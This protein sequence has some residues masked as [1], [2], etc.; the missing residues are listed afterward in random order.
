MRELRA[1]TYDSKVYTDVNAL[2][3]NGLIDQET[4]SKNLTYLWGKDSDMFPLLSMTQAQDAFKSITPKELNDTQYTWPV[5]GRMKWTTKIVGLAASGLS[6]P[7]KT[8]GLF[9][10]FVEDA[11]IH[12][13]YS[14]FTPD[15]LHQVRFMSEPKFV[16]TKKYRVTVQ[17]ITSDPAEYVSL[18]NFYAGKAWAMGS[19]S[20][21]GSLSDGTTSNRMFPGK[22][23]NQFGW[24][25]YSKVITGN[26]ANKVV[27]IE[28]DLEGG[29][30]TSYWLP[31]ELKQW[32]MERRMIDEVDLWTSRY[33]RDSS[34]VIHLLDTETG[35]PIPK[36]AGVKEQIEAAGNYDTFS[37]LTK[38]K[39]D[40]TV[41]SI[42]SNRVDNTQMEIV[43]YTGEGGAEAFHTMLMNEAKDYAVALGEH[44]ISGGEYLTYGAYFNQYRLN[45]GKLLTIRKTKMFDQGTLAQQDR[46]NGRVYNGLPW[47]SYNMVFMDHSKDDGG[48]RN[49]QLVT[50]KGRDEIAGVYSGLTPLP[51]MWQTATGKGGIK[52][53]GTTK[54]KASYE[55]M[56]SRGICIKNATTCFWLEMAQ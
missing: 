7:G 27:N 48:E 18:D 16:S 30:K 54:D 43:M 19:T 13:Q 50:E 41:R 34:G 52:I 35:L 32:E 28:F 39:F 53:L 29:G 9:D 42:F 17:L 56:S 45:D 51:A 12:Y 4:L 46:E 33:N 55:V 37:T 47:S 1:V 31:F 23:T 38:A 44:V 3:Q 26:V 6:T 8:F 20:V 14:A 49:I 15:Q 11:F 24:S 22:L 5:M 36:G 25:R 10:I 21:A 2:Y 40:S